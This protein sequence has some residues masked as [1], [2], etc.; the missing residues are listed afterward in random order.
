MNMI[1]AEKLLMEPAATMTGPPDHFR[2]SPTEI[3][4]AWTYVDD[5]T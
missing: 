4:N 2:Q 3:K 1:N 5:S